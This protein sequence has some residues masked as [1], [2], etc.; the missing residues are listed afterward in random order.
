MFGE[1]RVKL[2][3]GTLLS[4]EIQDECE[5][6]GL[7]FVG[8]GRITGFNEAGFVAGMLKLSY[9]FSQQYARA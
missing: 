5:K 9:Y 7:M 2:L 3:C 4:E 1:D 6:T 8:R